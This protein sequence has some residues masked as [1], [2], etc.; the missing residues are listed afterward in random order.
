MEADEA[1]MMHDL[2]TSGAAST[3]MTV[4]QHD[5]PEA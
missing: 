3:P 1:K 5:Y 2:E 4:S